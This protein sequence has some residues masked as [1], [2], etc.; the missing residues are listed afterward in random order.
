MLA[1]WLPLAAALLLPGQDAAPHRARVATLLGAPRAQDAAWR[2]TLFQS[3]SRLEHEAVD[4]ALLAWRILAD[5]GGD[6]DRANLLLYQ[7]RHE[8]PLESPLLDEGVDSL[9]ERALCAW[10]ESRLGETQVALE[11]ASG[12]APEDDRILSNM[13]WLL[14][15]PPPALRPADDARATAHAVLAARGAMP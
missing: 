11:R 3:V 8:L 5:H 7:R 4:V 15:R 2:G 1:A 14:Q 13:D 10:G 9:L 12:L 6:S